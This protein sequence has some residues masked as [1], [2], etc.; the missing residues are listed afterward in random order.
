MIKLI[1]ASANEHK[2]REI[3]SILGS[4]FSLGSLSDAGITEDI[5]E[6]EDTLE[7][8]ALSKARYVHRLTGMNVFADDTGL[9]VTALGGAPGVHSARFAG[10]AKNPSDNI[11]KLLSLLGN[12]SNRKAR[13]R[14]VIALILD[15]REHLF[16]G[17][18]EGRIINEKRGS[19]GFGY[20]P[21]FVPEGHELTFAEMSLALKNTISH[22]ARA[23]EAL[24]LFLAR[25]EAKNNKE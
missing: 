13:F 11:D 24:R 18:A 16:E 2:I 17:V 9:E 7:G 25:R 8:N 3:G 15:G 23:F 4:S 6:N 21:V 20:D 14:T 5:P 22:R 10:E 1:F 19:E 12:T